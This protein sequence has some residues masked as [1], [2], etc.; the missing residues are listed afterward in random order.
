MVL[1]MGCAIALCALA[2]DNVT[3]TLG[4]SAAARDDPFVYCAQVANIDEPAGGASTLP[5]VLWPHVRRAL[6][7]SAA[8]KPAP[9]SY[10]W[11]C[12]DGAVFICAIGANIR[13]DA[14]ADRATRNPGADNYCRENRDA[15]LVPAYA[16]G[17]N[18]IYEW[19]C[20]AG[21]AVRG[22]QVAKLD[23]RGYRSDIWYRIS[24]R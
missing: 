15:A 6:G 24:A 14:K 2:T 23:R 17:H 1:P 4:N 16:T 20:N 11:R 7:L 22:K 8:A 13:C 5:P 21:S 12:M 9:Q 3:A 19:S 18:G 10:Y